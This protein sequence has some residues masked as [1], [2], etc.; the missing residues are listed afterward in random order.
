MPCMSKYQNVEPYKMGKLRSFFLTLSV[1]LVYNFKL[2]FQTRGWR[3]WSEDHRWLCPWTR[4]ALMKSFG[5]KNQSAASA[6]EVA[7]GAL[8]DSGLRWPG[9][10]FTL[11]MLDGRL[12]DRQAA[13]RPPKDVQHI[14]IQLAV[15]LNRRIKSQLTLAHSYLDAVNGIPVTFKVIWDWWT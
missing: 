14:S 2:V 3:S 12:R 9:W 6:A 13:S 1:P 5:L 7:D 11:A 8:C 15:Y 4:W 10:I